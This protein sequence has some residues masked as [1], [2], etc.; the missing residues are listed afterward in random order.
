MKEMIV[1]DFL[2]CSLKKSEGLVECHRECNTS[3]VLSVEIIRKS[4]IHRTSVERTF[5]TFF[6][7]T[8]NRLPSP[9]TGPLGNDVRRVSCWGPAFTIRSLTANERRATS[10]SSSVSDSSEPF[11]VLRPSNTGIRSSGAPASEWGGS[12]MN[13]SAPSGSSTASNQMLPPSLREVTVDAHVLRA[14]GLANR[15]GVRLPSDCSSTVAGSGDPITLEG[16]LSRDGIKPL[17]ASC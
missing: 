15:A 2:C 17:R 8:A 7:K 12:R 6:L 16:M 9:A 4:S 1:F 10:A 3:K 14:I 5:P 13:S 11:E